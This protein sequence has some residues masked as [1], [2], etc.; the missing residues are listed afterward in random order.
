MSAARD[1]ILGR[2]REDEIERGG[3]RLGGER[4]RVGRP[5][6]GYSR[7]AEHLPRQVE[8]RQRPLEDDA[9]A[10]EP[11]GSPSALS[12][13]RRLIQRA[14]SASSSSR[15]RKT[16]TAAGS[17]PAS[18]AGASNTGGAD[19]VGNRVSSI[20]GNASCSRSCQPAASSRFGGDDVEALDTGQAGQQIEV[21]RPQAA[22]VRRPDRRR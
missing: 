19:A 20:P 17:A 14:A 2:H 18:A 12:R 6:S 11:D 9:G 21:R 3:E 16:K 4:Q 15:S 8:V 22:R 7:G 5:D 10:L 13:A 1:R